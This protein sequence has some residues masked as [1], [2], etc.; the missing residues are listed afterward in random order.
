MYINTSLIEAFATLEI[1]SSPSSLVIALNQALQLIFSLLL[2]L[3]KYDVTIDINP[4][5]QVHMYLST[6]SYMSIHIINACT[7]YIAVCSLIKFLYHLHL[8]FGFF[9]LLLSGK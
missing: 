9:K 4:P 5:I 6:T 1:T 3:C 8:L 7:D 2:L